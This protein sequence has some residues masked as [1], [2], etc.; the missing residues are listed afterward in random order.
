[1]VVDYGVLFSLTFNFLAAVIKNKTGKMPGELV[2]RR[3]SRTQKNRII[4]YMCIYVYLFLS[5][6][7]SYVVTLLE[8][9]L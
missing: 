7:F 3:V 4:D 6:Y 5:F 9:F 8:N 2:T 1:M